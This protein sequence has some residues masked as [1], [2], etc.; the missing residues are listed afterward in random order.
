MNPSLLT[1]AL[2]L[3]KH[4]IRCSA[5]VRFKAWNGITL[6]TTLPRLIYWAHQQHVSR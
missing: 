4:S 1:S 3:L 5:K 6:N 2:C